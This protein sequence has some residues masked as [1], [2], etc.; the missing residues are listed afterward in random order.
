VKFSE[1]PLV[2]LKDVVFPTLWLEHVNKRQQATECVGV[3]AGAAQPQFR[4]AVFHLNMLMTGT[5]AGLLQAWDQDRHGSVSHLSLLTWH[6]ACSQPVVKVSLCSCAEVFRVEAHKM[7]ITDMSIGIDK[8]PLDK[9]V[10]TEAQIRRAQI[11][12]PASTTT[13]TTLT[14]T[15][16]SITV[17]ATAAATTVLHAICLD[18]T[19]VSWATLA[20]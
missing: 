11:R 2:S 4:C 10:T 16:T 7:A 12:I 20:A 5:T 17:T 18:F 13:T 9:M 19:D 14:T 6:G 3:I 8:S 15:T 1:S